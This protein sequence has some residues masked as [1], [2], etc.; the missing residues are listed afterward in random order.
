MPES[1]FKDISEF[2]Q[3]SSKF[4]SMFLLNSFKFFS[5][6]QKRENIK[7]GVKCQRAK[8][9]KIEA[10]NA[11]IFLKMFEDAINTK[12]ANVSKMRGAKI[13]TQLTT[14]S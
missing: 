1:S 9:T 13:E 6:M 5:K 14:G 8:Y 12:N 2:L 10:K 11:N 7:R 4:L 3:S